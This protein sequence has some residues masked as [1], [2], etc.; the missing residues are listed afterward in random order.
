M[1]TFFE[2]INSSAPHIYHSALE[3]SP[4][5]SIVRK[6]YYHQRTPFPKVAT[7]I[8][9][10]WEPSTI[11]SS[12][13][14]SHESSVTWSPC[15]QFVATTTKVTVEIR[16]ALTFGLS[17]TLQPTEPTS[18]LTGG[19]AYSPDGRSVA[20]FSDTTIIIWDIQTGGVV[21]EIQR[22]PGPTGSPVCRWMEGQSVP[23]GAILA[24]R[25]YIVMMLRQV[26]HSPPSQF[27]HTTNHT[28]GPTINI[29]G[30]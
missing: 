3:L 1:K 15:S 4:L 24:T 7:G 9:D 25:P 2:P 18:Q 17:T 26:Q 30:S 12:P 8:P 11:I 10:S 22:D 6:L 13:D 5:S 21:K 23:W 14:Y 16:D 20:W 29:F 28:Y 19:L 27:S